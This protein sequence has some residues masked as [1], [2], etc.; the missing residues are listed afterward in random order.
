MLRKE[1][2]YIPLK[3]LKIWSAVNVRKT[4]AYSGIEDLK[5][6]IKKIGMQVPLVVVPHKKIF[7]I[8]SGSR[9]FI[10]A[11]KAGLPEVPCF[12]KYDIDPITAT[13]F[14][15]SE[16]LF[17][18]DMTEEDKSNAAALLKDKLGGKVEEVAKRLGVSTPTV[19][20]YLSWRKVFPRLRHLVSEH[21]ITPTVAKEIYKKYPDDEKFAYDLAIDY[22]KREDKTSYYLAIK[23]AVAGEKLE[24]IQKR[25]KEYQSSE[26]FTIRLPKSSSKVIKD[27][28]DEMHVKDT[29]VL[30]LLVQRSLDLVIDGKVNL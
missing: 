4:S 14:S 10:A 20:N 28:A 16:N 11:G 24:S 13:I 15:F 3:K 29:Y 1:F 9:R 18:E 25:F 6:N 12:I 19:Y 21:K 26:P 2:D 22:A 27:L 17:R 7:R 23:D 8:I 5:E 30:T